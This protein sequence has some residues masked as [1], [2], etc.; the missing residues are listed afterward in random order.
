VSDFLCSC[1]NRQRSKL[2]PIETNLLKKQQ[3][4]MCSPC[5]ESGHEPR[6]LIII[7]ARSSGMTDEL[8]KL[9]REEKYC[10]KVIT[11]IELL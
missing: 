11:G 1:C 8:I 2:T 10:G 6:W 9:I 3:L 7:S 4:I 5:L